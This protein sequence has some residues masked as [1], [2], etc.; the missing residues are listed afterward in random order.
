MP[1]P[2]RTRPRTIP[3]LIG[4]LVLPALLA[5]G[6]EP[7]GVTP[8]SPE[9][10]LSSPPDDVLI[11]DVRSAEEYAR[12]HVP[13]ALNIPHTEVGA[14]LDELSGAQHRPVVVYCEKG[15]RAGQAEATLLAA[16]FTDLHHLEGDMSAWRAAG[17]V[18]ETP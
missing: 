2:A 14:R 8:L 4:L 3:I 6:S 1:Q 7:A 18:V 10:L 9:T 16:G 11:L 13:G 12:G 17:R 5:C 15:G